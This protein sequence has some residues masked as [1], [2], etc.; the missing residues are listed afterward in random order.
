MGEYL[1]E[2]Y[3][4]SVW[5]E[6]L[7]QNGNETIFEE[8]KLATIG[9]DKM[10]GFNKVFKPIFN[11]KTNGEKTL[12]FSLNYKYFDP[13]S[14][15]EGVVNPFVGLLTNERKVKLHYNGEWYEFIVKDHSESSEDYVWT[16]TCEDAFVLELSKIGYNITFDTELNNNQGTA[17]ELATET[18]KNTSWRIGEVSPGRQYVAEPIYEATINGFVTA[19]NLDTNEQI[20]CSGDIYL[21]YSYVK[22]KDGKFVQFIKKEDPSRIIDDKYVITSTN[23]RIL[24]EVE[25]TNTAIILNGT[26][27]ISIDDINTLYQANRIVY[28]QMTTYDP[29]MQRT[30]DRFKSGDL[31]IY[32]YTDYL[33]TTSNVITNFITN[34]ENFNVLED[35]TLQGWS[36]YVE[37]SGGEIEPLELVTKPKFGTGIELADISTISQIEGFLKVNF[38]G[39]LT[40]DYRNAIFNSGFEN[41]TFLIDHVAKG[42][43]FVFRWRAG[44]GTDVDHMTE[45]TNLCLLVAKYTEEKSEEDGKYYKK[46][47]TDNIILNFVGAPKK[48][49]NV[50]NGGY[51]KTEEIDGK[52]I[53]NYIIDDVV[54]TA[55]TKYIY[56][57]SL[58]NKQYVWNLTQKRFDELT[59]SNYLSYYYLTAEATRA[60]TAAELAEIPNKYG[61]FIYNTNRSGKYFIE[62][63]QLTNYTP[64]GSDPEGTAP[65]DRT[66]VTL[67]NIPTAVS[68]STDFY[69]VKPKE[70]MTVEDVVTYLTPESLASDL[71]LP[72]EIKPIYNEDAEKILSISASK[73]NC[74]DI[75]QTIAE[76]FECWVDLNVSHDDKGYI[77][78]DEGGQQKKFVYLREYVGHDNYAGFKYGINL[79]SIERQINS[80]EIVTKLL[81]DQSQS[82]YVDEGFVS[83]ASA[84]SNASGESYI[85]NFDYYY[86]Q[87]L[88]DRDTVEKD[89]INF[90]DAVSK[91]NSDLKEK[92]AERRTL[93]NSLVA[94]RSKRNVYGELL[95]KAYEMQNKSLGEFKSLTKESYEEYREKHLTLEEYE[96]LT[97]EE[98]IV[99]VLGRLYVSCV[100]INNYSGLYTNIEQEYL[101]VRKDLKGSEN[102]YVK[103]WVNRDV[104]ENRH[105]YVELNDYLPGF[106]FEI[107][108]TT[109]NVTVNKKYFDI[110]SN[111]TV[112]NFNAPQEYTITP[113]QYTID[114]LKVVTFKILSTSSDTGVEGKI[115]ELQEDKEQ[116]VNNF[117]KKYERYLQ[118]GTWNSTD[119]IDPELYYL[120]ALQVSNTSAQ[121]TV[122]YTINV[123]D[124]SQIDGLE[125]YN[126]DVGDKT[127]IEDTEFFGWHGDNIGDENNPKI[128]YT[129]ARE[130]VI[131]SEIEWHLDEPSE[132]TIT[133]QNYKSRFEDLF[134]RISATVQTVQ[135]N[136]ATYAKT[137]T[138]LDENGNFNQNVLINS[139]NEARGKNYALTSDG[140]VKI[141]GDNILIQNLDNTANKLLLNSKGL[142]ISSDGG[143]TWATAIDGQGIN[144]GT[145]YTGTLNTN[146]V[147][148]GNSEN[149]SFR[150][151][152]AGISAFKSDA[153][154]FVKTMD[155]TVDANK[156]Y[157]T[158][159]SGTNSYEPVENPTDVNL[160]NY[161]EE[162]TGYDLQTYVRYDQY[163]L[164]GIKKGQT[165]KAQNLQEVIDKAHFAVTWDGFFIRNSY[166]GGGKVSITSANDFQV[167]DGNDTERVKIGALEWT[168]NGQRQTTPVDGIAPSLYGI[169]INNNAGDTVFKT[170]D[171]G[172]LTITGTL[173]ATGGNFTGIVN[174]GPENQ[175]H[176]IIDGTNA[177]IAT[178]TYQDGAGYGWKI[179]KDGDA[180]FNNITARGSIK[181]AVFE[182]AE[183]QAVG[184]IFM[185]RPSS[186][187][188]FATLDGTDLVLTVEKPYLFKVGDW[189]KVSNYTTNGTEPSAAGILSNNG[190]THTYKITSVTNNGKVITLENAGAMVSGQTAITDLASLEG[191]ALVDMGDKANGD[192]EVGSSNYGI[193]IN[194]SDNTVNLP[195]RAISLFETIIDETKNPKVS[196]NYRGILGTLPALQ[197]TGAN[198][199]V[200]RYYHDYLENTQGIYTDNMYIGDKN[201]YIVFYTDNN[202]NKQLR[203]SARQMVF[204]VS[205]ETGEEITWEEH[206]DD[207][208]PIR[209]EIE[210]S[211]GNMFIRNTINTQ[212]TCTVY[213]GNEDITNTVTKFNWTKKNSDGTIDPN[214][215]RLAGGRTI[216]ISGDDV[217]SK[218]TFTCSVEF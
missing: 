48:L 204:E 140:A 109:Y 17:K 167:I 10:T 134:Q 47:D 75:L 197:Y 4:I 77:E 71:E 152:K 154:V 43:K 7:I 44:Y 16:Y 87:G 173:N 138:F 84:P 201:Q 110:E 162:Q 93:E 137:S 106:S 166:T 207:Q 22:N 180:V 198:A 159:N 3:E 61:I 82:D 115:K 125:L 60:V 160:N 63:I 37:H 94:L 65:Q 192:G 70:G 62:D 41:N 112:I 68:T 169:R 1:I 158:Y 131:V 151:D 45:A 147:I 143:L 132:N 182:Y 187:I 170:G 31:E 54:Q 80:E 145:V 123:V 191:G 104:Y 89:K 64:E 168:V 174:V 20:A 34:G 9:S 124:V 128:V 209:V 55:S 195:R 85:L 214:W 26:T 135:Y 100:T 215:S 184:G 179:N 208:I 38:N 172:N 165:F 25:V 177:S 212:L 40:E 155:R 98:T 95:S 24:D 72:N 58:D 136:E 149:P 67:G 156:Q 205:P 96:Q 5:E 33:Y 120:D 119:Y 157:Y 139:L 29:V 126:F 142:Q 91:I 164:Y 99:K 66:P 32:K 107:D 50:I 146:E 102:F 81:V 129:P 86:N 2:P 103:V 118:E 111:G 178:S 18:I 130:E 27:I 97:E 127:Y 30:V 114:D 121:P 206:I 189:C 46:I 13:F 144:I 163:G 141:D 36:P 35:G 218:A 161:Y 73:S 171:D 117:N 6:K 188:R 11:K 92:E 133:V 69:Y 78:K 200:S 53:S 148:I 52:T 23:Y 185:F 39:G 175:D 216:T 190:L 14:E 88:L 21:F 105:V 116:L 210:S 76:T 183:I 15:N 57:N 19:L 74:F 202:G 193:G 83:I 101:K 150:W 217:A 153:E 122:E 90:V 176:I 28:N 203:I 211:N 59:D 79:N 196:Y 199:Q 42:Q 181:T 194:S 113:S 108:G 56:E 51:I 12:T 213:K 49:N 186:A 8:N